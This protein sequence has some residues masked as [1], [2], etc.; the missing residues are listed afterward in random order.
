VEVIEEPAPYRPRQSKRRLAL[1][2]GEFERCRGD[3]NVGGINRTP[4]VTALSPIRAALLAR[5]RDG[6]TDAAGRTARCVRGRR[7]GADPAA[8]YQPVDEVGFG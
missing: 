5:A 2:L 8:L 3:L 1:L 7:G 4:I 6:W